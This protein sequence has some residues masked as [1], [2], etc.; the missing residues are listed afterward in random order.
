MGILILLPHTYHALQPLDVSVFAPLNR[1]LTV[2][3]DAP[4]RLDLGRLQR[5]G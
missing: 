1:A 4:S 5:A 3:L 2:Q